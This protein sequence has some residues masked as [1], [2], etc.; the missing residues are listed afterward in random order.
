MLTVSGPA[1]CGVC[2]L[3][4]VPIAISSLYRKVDGQWCLLRP[5]C[6]I[7]ENSKLPVWEQDEEYK[8]MFCND[9][10]SCPLYTRFQPTMTSDM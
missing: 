1:N 7:I 5:V 2:P 4:D 3:W 6:P 8:Y 9:C 10:F